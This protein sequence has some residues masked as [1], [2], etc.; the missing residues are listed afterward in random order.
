[1]EQQDDAKAKLLIARALGLLQYVSKGNIASNHVNMIAALLLLNAEAFVQTANRNASQVAWTAAWLAYIEAEDYIQ[2][3]QANLVQLSSTLYWNDHYDRLYDGMVTTAFALAVFDE[4][5]YEIGLQ[6][7]E[8]SKAAYLKSTLQHKHLK[9]NLPNAHPLSLQEQQLLQRLLWIENSLFQE[10]TKG[11]LANTEKVKQL[12]QQQYTF[13]Q[14]LKNIQAQLQ[15]TYPAILSAHPK[16]SSLTQW[17]EKLQT[18]ECVVNYHVTNNH[19]FISVFN[20][21]SLHTIQLPK[22]KNFENQLLLLYETIQVS[23]SNMAFPD[24]FYT[25]YTDLAHFFY[26]QLIQPIEHRLEKRVLVIPDKLLAYLPFE[27]LLR[28]PVSQVYDFN[29]HDY[30]LRH[31][32]FSYS[33]AIQLWEWSKTQTP[34]ASTALLAIAPYFDS[35]TGL[36]PLAHNNKEAATIRR[37][38]RGKLIRRQEAQE[39]EFKRL[40]P[41]YNIFHFATHGITNSE[42]PNFSYL[43]FAHPKDSSEDGRLYAA[44]I[45]QMSIPAELIF[46]SA[47]QTNLGKYHQSEGLMSLA[48]AFTYTGAKSIIATLWSIDDEQTAWVANAFY[49]YLKQ[50]NSKD[51][52]LQRAKLDYIAQSSHIFA[53]PYYWSAMILIGDNHQLARASK[54]KQYYYIF[55][56]AVSVL[57]IGLAATR[58]KLKKWYIS[59]INMGTG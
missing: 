32:Q 39:K 56:F 53:H 13:Q 10:D 38:W 11:I 48:R 26:Q 58:K 22:P 19:I 14:Q 52:A 43:A 17:Q 6:Y 57:I 31:Y 3:Q 29:T 25:A 16:L 27:V 36:Q 34:A 54:S 7:T 18:H 46:L 41:Q 8:R 45:Y 37:L 50:P 21:D 33:S 42:Y 1:M 49:K 47:C 30:L 44:E 40:L 28:Q 35:A 55:W 12:Q 59:K 23:P 9:N 20:S 4:N 24:S 51:E 5:Y 15:A 2:Q